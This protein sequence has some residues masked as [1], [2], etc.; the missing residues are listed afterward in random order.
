MFVAD[1][2]LPGE[3]VVVLVVTDLLEPV[4]EVYRVL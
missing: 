4:E 1:V 2:P 3:A